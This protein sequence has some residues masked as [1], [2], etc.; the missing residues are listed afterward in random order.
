M[1]ID[2]HQHFWQYNSVKD[3]WINDQMQILKQDFMPV[4]LEPLLVKHQIDG[5]IAVQADQSEKETLFLLELATQY[6]FIKGVVGWVDLCS[7]NIEERLSF[8]SEYLF[9]KGFRHI[10][11]AEPAND[12]MLSPNFCKGI[13]CLSLYG[14]TYDLLIYPKH[15]PYA[16]QLV[17]QFPQQKFVIDHLAKPN[18]KA[19]QFEEWETG[20]KSIAKHQNVYCKVSGLVTEADWLHWTKADFTYC[21]DTI[22]EA[23][24]VDRLMFGSDWPVCLLGGSYDQTREIINSYF[25]QFSKDERAKLDGLTAK[26]FYQ[27]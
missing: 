14:Y 10:L 19:Q 12:F 4:D 22:V 2:S 17:Q 21:L 20:I 18:I 25:N 1:R 11:Q 24:G 9:L 27:L 15:L 6:S 5:C 7:T 13:G 16:L 23:F 8:F 26:T 3:A